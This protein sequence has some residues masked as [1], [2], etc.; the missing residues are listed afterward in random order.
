MVAGCS[1]GGG[2]S[3]EPE[4]VL[5]VVAPTAQAIQQVEDAASAAD[6]LFQ[7]AETV[8][9][10]SYGLLGD[11]VTDNTAAF[12]RVLS[13]G[14]RT[15]QIPAGD[16][17]TGKI[18]IPSNTILLL[19]PGVIIRD[20][21]AL[22]SNERLINIQT[23]NVRIVGHGASVVAER[24]DYTSGEQRHGVFIFGAKRIVIEGLDSSGH[25]GDGFYIGGPTGNPS[26]DVYLKG[27]R[28]DNNRRQG[29]SITSARRVRVTD[30]EF[31]NTNGTAPQFGVDLEPNRPTDFLDDIILLRPYTQT[32]RGGGI[33]IYLAKLDATSHPVH[34]SVVGHTTSA[35]APAVTTHVPDGVIATLQYSR[36]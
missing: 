15:I 26:I 32:N 18:T 21:G 17:V 9:G 20:S 36:D 11:G 8:D 3:K 31:S 6:L 35:E 28:A 10:L 30:C 34:V 22:A 4:P 29:L 5:G 12:Q 1:S 14:N 33:Q 7:T 16:Y 27:C 13:Q 23:E 19:E 25:G 2:A 24:S